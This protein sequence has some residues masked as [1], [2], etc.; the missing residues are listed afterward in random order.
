MLL[1]E[2]FEQKIQGTPKKEMSYRKTKGDYEEE[3]CMKRI[4]RDFKQKITS[5]KVNKQMDKIKR[6]SI[7]EVSTRLSLEFV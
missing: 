2:S 1:E 5:I 7:Q 6:Q 3:M 4:D